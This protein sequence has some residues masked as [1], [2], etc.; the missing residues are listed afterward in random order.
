[1]LL[2]PLLDVHTVGAGGGSIARVDAGGLLHVGP[3]SAGAVP[4]PAGYGRGGP[5]TVTDALVTLGRIA[6][7]ALAG[8]TLPLGRPAAVL[9]MESLAES[10]RA[11]SAAEAAEGVLLVAEARIEAALRKVS[12]ERGH[13]PRDAALVAFG[14]AGGLHAC[15]VAESLGTPVV[16]FPAQAGVLSALGALGAESRRECSRPV[17][18]PAADGAAIE[19]ALSE[20]EREVRAGFPRT[21]RR[22]VRIE[23]RAEVRYRGQSHELSLAAC[24]DLAGRFHREH[25]RRFGFASPAR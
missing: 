21:A 25:A 14:G 12:V 24:P 22:G 15:P 6:G 17:L 13:D 2:L 18:L 11:R 4:G 8:G 19:R 7:G 16:L 5:P 3:E 23:R 10:L 20:L 1:P 9:A